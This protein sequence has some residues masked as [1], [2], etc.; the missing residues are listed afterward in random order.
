MQQTQYRSFYTH[1]PNVYIFIPLNVYAINKI[2]IHKSLQPISASVIRSIT[3]QNARTE[4][5]ERERE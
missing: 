1:Y 4:C 2:N 3:L 5:D